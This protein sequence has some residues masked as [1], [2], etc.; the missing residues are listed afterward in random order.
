MST[1]PRYSVK[2]YLLILVASASV[3]LV[4]CAFI[5]SFLGDVI[6]F[7]SQGVLIV[8]LFTFPF[9]IFSVL[10]GFYKGLV[11]HYGLKGRQNLFFGGKF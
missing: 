7:G 11:R 9:C 10:Y 5:V 2:G 4:L 6:G 3:G 1:E 8:I